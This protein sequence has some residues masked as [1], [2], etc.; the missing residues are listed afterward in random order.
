MPI[1]DTFI[2]YPT[3]ACLCENGARG[4]GEREF[5]LPNIQT[6]QGNGRPPETACMAVS[7]YDSSGNSS[8]PSEGVGLSFVYLPVVLKNHH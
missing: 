3:S 2:I 5:F 8:P 1:T 6:D 4:E 7:A